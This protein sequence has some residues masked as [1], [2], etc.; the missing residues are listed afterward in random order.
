MQVSSKEYQRS[1]EAHKET[2][3]KLYCIKC[4]KAVATAQQVNGITT[5]FAVCS[6]C[7]YNVKGWTREDMKDEKRKRDIRN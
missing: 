4:Q 1:T 6:E 5:W 7:L 3:M 2:K